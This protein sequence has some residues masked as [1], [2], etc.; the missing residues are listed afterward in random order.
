[1]GMIDKLSYQLLKK[2]EY[3]GDFN[4]E[5]QIGEKPIGLKKKLVGAAYMLT[6]LYYPKYRSEIFEPQV[7]KAYDF[8]VMRKKIDAADVVSFDIFDT[9]LLRPVYQPRDMFYFLEKDNRVIDFRKKRVRAEEWARNHTDKENGEIDIFDIYHCLEEWC[10]IDAEKSAIEEM[11][12]EKKYCFAHP[13]VKKMYQYALDNHKTV[14]A[15]SDMYIPKEYMKEI[16][17]DNGYDNFNDIFVSCDYEKSKYNGKLYGLVKKKYSGKNILHIGDNR[18][19]DIIVAKKYGLSTIHIQNVNRAGEKYRR[20]QHQSF[21]Q[22]VYC[23]L[24]DSFLYTGMSDWVEKCHNAHFLYGFLCG[25][26]LTYGLCQWLDDLAL[27]KSADKILFLARDGFIFSEVYTKYFG[28]VKSEYIMASRQALLPV[29]CYLDYDMYLQEAFYKRIVYAK[30]RIKETLLDVGIFQYFDDALKK[31]F[32]I[33]FSDNYSDWYH[34]KEWMLSKQDDIKKIYEKPLKAID[35]YYDDVI[36]DAKK[37]LL[38]DLGWRGTSILYLKKYLEKTHEN[39]EVYGAMLGGQEMPMTEIWLSDHTIET[40]A[41]S[42]VKP[43]IFSR[44]NNQKIMYLNERFLLENMFTSTQPSLISYGEE[45]CKLVFEN[46]DV[47]SNNIMIEHMH[48]GIRE[49]C[50]WY[51]NRIT[52]EYDKRD[53]NLKYS[54]QP[55]WMFLQNK[56]AKKIFC[57]FSEGQYTLHGWGKK[58]N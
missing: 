11:E 29:I 32:E 8:D 21:S 56:K 17:A 2:N 57:K 22:S 39:I 45:N 24:V 41:F 40:Y 23:G 42:E 30:M 28:N 26:P 14:I 50:S 51:R 54:L 47:S 36:G 37:L 13:F 31:D 38:F 27:K 15:T 55:M 19:S 7:I 49:Y 33:A 4:E 1:M 25:G 48:D 35:T 9:L 10:G 16:L 18:Y 52:N 46:F 34:F 5:Y 6:H 3:I 44:V 43:T 12:A 58:V 53:S 20:F